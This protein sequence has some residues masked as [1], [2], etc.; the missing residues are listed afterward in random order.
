VVSEDKKPPMYKARIAI[1]TPTSSKG[2]TMKLIPG[3]TTTNEVVIGQRRII[4]F[5]LDPLIDH[6]DTSL[7]VR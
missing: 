7:K 5:F 3:M 1:T 4:D 6:T 2:Q